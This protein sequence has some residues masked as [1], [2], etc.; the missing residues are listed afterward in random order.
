MKASAPQ[1]KRLTRHWTKLD[2]EF[3]AAALS[4]QECPRWER[5]EIALLGRS[6]VGKSSLLNAIAGVRALAR[7]S[8]TPGRTRS[9]NLFTVGDSIAIAD[10][11]GFGY[12]KM[13]QAE[14]RR[15]AA[16]MREYLERRENLIA[17]V[18][19]VDARRGPEEEEIHLSRMA[20][21]RGLG[22]IVTATKC[23]R[24]RRAERARALASFASLG[25]DPIFCSAVT[26]EGIV[27]LRRRVLRLAREDRRMADGAGH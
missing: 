18:L 8:K 13:S 5:N 21:A 11:P 15:L 16:A 6:N 27:E 22:L 7:V 24:L 26:G 10:L 23:D 4:V 9:I 25:S 14:A 19:L 1:A 12:A 2:A 20:S 17:L 3:A